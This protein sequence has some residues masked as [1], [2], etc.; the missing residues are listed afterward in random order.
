MKIGFIG[1]GNMGEALI[2]GII[3]GGNIESKNII[4]YDANPDK[5]QE[6]ITKYGVKTAHSNQDLLTKTDTV[7]LAIKPNI[8]P[9]VLPEISNYLTAEH[10]ILSLAAGYDFSRIKNLLNYDSANN[11]SS[12]LS[13]IM[14]NT[15]ARIG[16]AVTA[17]CF[18]ANLT[19][20]NKLELIRLFKS[21]GEFFEVSE[22]QMPTITSV[23]GSVPALVY[24]AI[25]GIMQGAILEGLP[26][27]QAKQIAAGVV[28]SA[29]NM[30]LETGDHP[31][32]LRDRICS[33]GGTT[34]EGVSYLK[35]AGFEGK[36][37][38][39]IRLMAEKARKM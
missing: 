20:E 34:I 9:I 2:S 29:A 32:I 1:T 11:T 26:A 5:S 28:A 16:Q 7:I 14:S 39:A 18:D 36:L 37:I 25:E 30:I 23:I 22:A 4:I 38:D 15:S 3:K 24:M 33:P 31:S 8:Y 27:E 19:E 13:L 35:S 17:A 10:H 12:K 21:V 6:M